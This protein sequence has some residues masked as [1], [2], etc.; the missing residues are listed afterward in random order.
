MSVRFL[1]LH[2]ASG[3]AGDARGFLQHGKAKNEPINDLVPRP[4]HCFFFADA[5]RANA[6]MLTKI[7]SIDC[8]E[9]AVVAQFQ[10]YI[11]S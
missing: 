1:N 4:L 2:R 8:S 7:P 10:L 11:F 6:S 9:S 5:P 3:S